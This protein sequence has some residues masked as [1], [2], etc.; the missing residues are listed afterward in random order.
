MASAA[1]ET[2]MKLHVR[3]VT[4]NEVENGLVLKTSVGLERS[5]VDP[6]WG[7]KSQTQQMKTLDKLPACS[8]SAL[9]SQR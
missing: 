8:S 2:R 6:G 3:N 7:S 4:E 1:T 9:S 5:L